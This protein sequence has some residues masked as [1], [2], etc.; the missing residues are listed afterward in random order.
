MAH[1]LLFPSLAQFLPISVNKFSPAKLRRTLKSSLQILC[2]QAVILRNSF[3]LTGID[4]S[5]I[6]YAA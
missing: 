6:H 2:F 3:Y 4:V 5:I 1:P